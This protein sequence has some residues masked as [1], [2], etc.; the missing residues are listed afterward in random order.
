[1]DCMGI[2]AQVRRWTHSVDQERE[3]WLFRS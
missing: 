2:T 1:M 3:L